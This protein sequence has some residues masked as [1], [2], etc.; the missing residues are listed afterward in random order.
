MFHLFMRAVFPHQD[1]LSGHAIFPLDKGTPGR[2]CEYRPFARD[3]PSAQATKSS[4]W[5]DQKGW[6][7]GDV[8]TGGWTVHALATH[9]LTFIPVCCV[10]GLAREG[11][12]SAACTEESWS[13]FDAY[14]NRHGLRGTEYKLTHAY[15]PRCVQQYV[16]PKK[17]VVEPDR[18][19]YERADITVAILKAIRRV[20]QCELDE[21][22][23]ACT[24]FT[25]NQIFLEVDR[26]SR[27]GDLHLTLSER[28]HYTVSLP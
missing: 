27:T 7:R 4:I 14:L 11:G 5:S 23:S 22:A 17:R 3:H 20:K 28:G 9:T 10:C 1:I 12:D 21:L 25:W 2:G 26:L 13:D 18:P 15:C 6:P 24:P 19:V 8:L 16:V